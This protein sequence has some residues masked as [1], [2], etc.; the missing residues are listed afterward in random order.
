MSLSVFLPTVNGFWGWC[1]LHLPCSG[2]SLFNHQAARS[3][4]S[5]VT[6]EVVVFNVLTYTARGWRVCMLVPGGHGK[7]EASIGAAN[8]GKMLEENVIRHAEEL[9]YC[10]GPR[11]ESSGVTVNAQ[12]WDRNSCWTQKCTTILAQIRRPEWGLCS[13]TTG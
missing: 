11:R 6:E 3:C 9:L 1:E 5:M 7:V 2:Y 10:R 8:Y 12:G 13:R 4:T